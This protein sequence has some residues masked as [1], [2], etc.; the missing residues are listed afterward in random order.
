VDPDQ[1]SYL[2]TARGR[3]GWAP[4]DVVLVYG[5]AGLAW[6]HYKGLDTQAFVAPYSLQNTVTTALDR[7]GWV[8]GVGVESVLFNSDWIGRMEYLHYGFGAVEAGRT[9]V[10]DVGCGTAL[11]QTKREFLPL[12]GIFGNA[13][14]GAAI[15]T[16]AHVNR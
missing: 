11:S 10:H 3:L 8:A 6:E 12:T 7:F 16:F 5:T 4:T 1:I 14:R 2:G 9:V 15:S 13:G